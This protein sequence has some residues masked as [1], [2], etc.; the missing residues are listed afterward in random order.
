MAQT[1]LPTLGVLP[2]KRILVHDELVDLT[3]RQHLLLA[4]LD[5][6]VGERD[7]GEGRLLSA[8]VGVPSGS[9]HVL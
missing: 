7:V 4:R 1:V 3:K 9:R 5:G 6:H 8:L 2:I